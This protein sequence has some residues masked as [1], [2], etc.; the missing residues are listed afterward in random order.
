MRILSNGDISFYED[1]GTTPKLFWDASA[2]RLGIGTSSP[3]SPLSLGDGASSITTF[4]LSGTNTGQDALFI[5]T[6][7][8]T[9]GLNAKGNSIGFGSPDGHSG[10]K[11]AIS[12]VQTDASDRDFVGLAFHTHNS[13]S[14][15]AD[16][17]EAMRITAD[18]KVGIGINSP[19]QKLEVSGKG[20]FSTAN[21]DV[22]GLKI[23][24]TT[25]TNASAMQFTNAVNGYV[26]LD[27]STGGR[28]GSDNYGL[29]MYQ[30]SGYPI[31]FHTNGT[32]RMTIDANGHVTMPYQ[33][34][35]SVKPSSNQT[36]ISVGSAVDVVFDSEFFDVG[37]NFASNTFTAPVTGKYQLNV[38]LYLNT[39]DTASAYYIL[40]IVTSNYS[41]VT[42]LDPNFS[43]DVDYYTMN[44]SVLA[45]MDAN[46]TAKIRIHQN[47]G[48]A[49]TDITGADSGF[50]GILVA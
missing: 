35:F 42:I 17:I 27:N 11:A 22:N 16:M 38:R 7:D 5:V 19:T 31:T 29:V 1:T 4:D 41:Y 43:A 30:G 26:G 47:N 40:N 46:D 2:E 21:P 3:S 36:N 24:A 13:A 18:G 44:S 37:S 34:A 25:G 48:T 28:F 15:S 9:A 45:D 20:V 10:R 39:I 12:A 50:S 49:Q 14:Q 23:T 8:E 32:K 6:S 33:P